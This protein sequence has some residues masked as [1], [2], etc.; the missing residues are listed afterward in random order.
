M[1][2]LFAYLNFL[3]FSIMNV[4]CT[5]NKIFKSYLQNKRRAVT[6]STSRSTG[7]GMSPVHRGTAWPLAFAGELVPT[8]QALCMLRCSDFAAEGLTRS[9]NNQKQRVFLH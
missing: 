5:C 2:L 3:H 9:L 8:R 6:E 7:K 4:Y 1:Y